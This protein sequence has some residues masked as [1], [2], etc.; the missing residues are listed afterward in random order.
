MSYFTDMSPLYDEVCEEFGWLCDEK[1]VTVMKTNNEAKL[2]EIDNK[3]EDAQQNLGETEV[4]DFMLEK[5]LHFTRIG[6]KVQAQ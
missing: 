6:D 3:I 1:Q 4:R 5:A 2:K